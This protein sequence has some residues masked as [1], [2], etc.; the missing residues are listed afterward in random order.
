MED[1]MTRVRI[2]RPFAIG[3]A[4]LALVVGR[5]GGAWAAPSG[6]TTV[7]YSLAGDEDGE[8]PDTDLVM[9]GAGN[10]YGTTVQGGDFGAGTVFQLSPTETGWVHTV[11]YSFRG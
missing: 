1:A 5:V 8:Y 2:S 9:D 4:A 11:L 10:L 7:A 6:S 3:L